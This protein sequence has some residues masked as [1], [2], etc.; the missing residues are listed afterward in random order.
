MSESSTAVVERSLT[1][2]AGFASGEMDFQLMRLLGAITY[3]GGAPGEI[4]HARGGS[5]R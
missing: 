5:R 2:V 4:F 3:G 1:R